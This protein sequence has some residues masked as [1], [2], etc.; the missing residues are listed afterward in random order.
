MKL[1]EVNDPALVE[2][3][4]TVPLSLYKNDP[5]FVRPLDSDIEKVFDKSANKYHEKGKCIR[6]VLKNDSGKPIGRIAAF[7]N[8]LTA[9]TYDQPTGGIGFFECINNKEAAFMLFDAAREWLKKQNMEAM[10]GPIN[11]GSRERWWGLLA[12]GFHPPCYCCNYN[13][14]WYRNFFEE[15]G[16]EVFFKQYT[17][18]RKTQEPLKDAYYKVA[19]RIFQNS[20]YSFRTVEKNRLD[21]Y[22]SDFRHVYNKAWVNHEGVGEMSIEE[23]RKTIYSLSPVI[24][25]RIAWFAYYQSEPI[26]FFLSIPELNELFVKYA[27]GKLT[28]LTKLKLIYNKLSGK[29]RTMYG[30]VFGIV[31]EHQKK[32]VEVAMIVAASNLLRKSKAYDEVQ[33]NW[34]GDF[35]P[36]MMRI[37]EQIGA[38]IYKTHHT[39]RYLFDRNAEFRRHPEI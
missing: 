39:Y 20:D 36:R 15:Y 16:F 32:G 3:F 21:S 31:P 28:F 1:S 37:A 18:W 13:P 4:L 6:W 26:G 29:C 5:A 7:V 8:P 22:V 12:D 24:D 9:Y 34:I 17:Y 10:D 27:H 33:M 38:K 35:N 30:L 25:D 19:Q 14:S 2:E 23:A 11:F